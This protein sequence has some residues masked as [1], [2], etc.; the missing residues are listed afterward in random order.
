MGGS[1]RIYE[2]GEW[3]N[4]HLMSAVLGKV[5]ERDARVGV[6]RLRIRT[7]GGRE[8]WCFEMACTPAVAPIQQSLF[9]DLSPAPAG[10][11]EGS[12]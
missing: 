10:A 1:E 4:A 3:V 2:V 12:R 5:I 7:E 9:S 8:L 6:P 11:K